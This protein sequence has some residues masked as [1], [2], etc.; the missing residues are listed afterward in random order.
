MNREV[1]RTYFH[2]LEKDQPHPAGF[3]LIGNSY[4]NETESLHLIVELSSDGQSFNIVCTICELKNKS[5]GNLWPISMHCYEEFIL[6]CLEIL[7]GNMVF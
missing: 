4:G 1:I 2:D 7:A 6:F 3:L 5:L